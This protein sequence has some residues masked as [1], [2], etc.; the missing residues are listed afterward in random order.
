MNFENFSKL[1]KDNEELHAKLE[2]LRAQIAEERRAWRKRASMDKDLKRTI[3]KKD[4]RI[5]ELERELSH[6]KG[7]IHDIL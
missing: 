4:I 6:S 2:K 7:V 1:K 5:K 3:S